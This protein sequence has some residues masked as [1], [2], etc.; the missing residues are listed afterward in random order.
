M[1]CY[2]NLVQMLWEEG[3]GTGKHSRSSLTGVVHYHATGLTPLS[4][5]SASSCSPQ[6][7]YLKHFNVLMKK[8]IK[9]VVRNLALY[10]DLNTQL[11]PLT[12]PGVCVCLSTQ[13]CTFLENLFCTHVYVCPI[14]S[15]ALV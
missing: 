15:G 3:G 9:S 14:G 7:F 4:R 1:K 6:L 11:A 10:L 8:I 13:V 2:S 5:P 12:Y